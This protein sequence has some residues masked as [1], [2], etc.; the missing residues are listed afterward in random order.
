[1][2]H[3]RLAVPRCAV[4]A[5]VITSFCI[6]TATASS[7]GATANQSPAI[8]R[9]VADVCN[10]Q[11][12][13]LGEDGNHGSG[14]TLDVKVDVVRRLIDECGFNAVYFESSIYDFTDLQRHVDRG[15]ASPEMLADA[16]GGL[17][18]TTRE[19]D[20]LIAYLYTKANSG[21]VYLAGLDLQLGSATSVY[22]QSALHI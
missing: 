4:L 12:V 14:A 15:N 11:T 10:R 7:T 3:A 2:R 6:M 17:W 1:M 22:Q 18:S 21:Q 9:L 19:T 8:D 5:L 13:L 20:P 16:I